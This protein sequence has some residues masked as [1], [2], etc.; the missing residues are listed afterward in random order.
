MNI[1]PLLHRK[2]LVIS[3]SPVNFTSFRVEHIMGFEI[4]GL[5]NYFVFSLFS[6]A[7]WKDISLY[8]GPTNIAALS[9][10]N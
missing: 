1:A 10:S 4:F 8:G 6:T 3:I 9:A 2:M 7:S 5:H